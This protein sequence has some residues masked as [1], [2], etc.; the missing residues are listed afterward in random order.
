MPP[1]IMLRSCRA[2]TPT[3]SPACL[4]LSKSGALL[5]IERI[6]STSDYFRK[7]ILLSAPFPCAVVSRQ[8]NESNRDTLFLAE[9]ASGAN[10]SLRYTPLPSPL[11]IPTRS[12]ICRP[13]NFLAA[14]SAPPPRMTCNPSMN[15]KP[16]GRRSKPTTSH[17]ASWPRSPSWGRS[18]PSSRSSVRELKT[19]RRCA[20]RH[21]FRPRF[22]F[23]D[24]RRSAVRGRPPAAHHARGVRSSGLCGCHRL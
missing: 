4:A 14:A 2:E 17:R 1:E 23:A 5:A 11:S 16:V 20:C 9:D 8:I 22:G 18:A 12:T 3:I 24:C 10:R 6:V 13:A 19:C 7:G 15:G 21:R